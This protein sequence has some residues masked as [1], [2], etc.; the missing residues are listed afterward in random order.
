MLVPLHAGGDNGSYAAAVREALAK[1][2]EQTRAEGLV[3]V[4]GDLHLVDIKAWRERTFS[5]YPCETPIFGVAYPELQRRLFAAQR[6][7]GFE[8]N[9]SAASTPA[10]RVGEAFDAMLIDR[11]AKDHPTVDAFGECGEFHTH[12][13]FSAPA[14]KLSF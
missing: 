14:R 13:T 4:F 1:L 9:V 3:L 2:R 7:L 10:V 6:E 12:I 11:L 5:D 8:V